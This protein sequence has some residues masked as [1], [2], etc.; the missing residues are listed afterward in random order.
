MHASICMQLQSGGKEAKAANA[1]SNSEIT[2]VKLEACTK[3]PRGTPGGALKVLQEETGRIE[4]RRTRRGRFDKGK[5]RP[6]D[7]RNSR[8]MRRSATLL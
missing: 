1:G 5:I 6:T 4:A 2:P 3:H 7:R 8:N